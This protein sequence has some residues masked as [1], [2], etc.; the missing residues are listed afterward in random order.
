MNVLRISS[1]ISDIHIL[2]CN[3]SL[4]KKSKD[5]GEI[6][7]NELIYKCINGKLFLLIITF[8]YFCF[9]RV[10]PHGHQLPVRLS[11]QRLHFLSASFF[12]IQNYFYLY[13]AFYF[14]Y[15]PYCYPFYH[16]LR[17]F[18]VRVINII[19]IVHI[20]VFAKEMKLF[21]QFLFA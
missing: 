5:Y 3:S 11:F 9:F 13:H 2:F 12:S 6:L 7:L 8:Y 15:C 16:S 18:F 19:S 4:L 21:F 14:Y 10:C 1:S 20:L 17:Y